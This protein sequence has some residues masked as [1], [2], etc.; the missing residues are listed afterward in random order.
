MLDD[1]MSKSNR[2]RKQTKRIER[3]NERLHSAHPIR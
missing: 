2:N 1:I 3:K